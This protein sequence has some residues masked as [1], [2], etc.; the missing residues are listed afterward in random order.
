M[1]PPLLAVLPVKFRA[2]VLPIGTRPNSAYR[3]PPLPLLLLSESA[4]LVVKLTL[5][6]VI[7]DT[8]LF[9]FLALTQRPPA[10]AAAEFPLNEPP[11]IWIVGELLMCSPPP[12][13]VCP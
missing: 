12:P 13:S 11:L 10:L 7:V 1:P 9:G 6:I 5:L 4:V 2:V 3:P 8:L